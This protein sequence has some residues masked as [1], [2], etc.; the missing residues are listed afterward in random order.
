MIHLLGAGGHAS[1]VVDVA[2]RLGVLDITVWSESEPRTGRFPAMI[3]W[4]SLDQLSPSTPVILAIGDI[5]KRAEL[6]RRFPNAP[7]PLI[8]PSVIVGS[9][10]RIAAGTVIMPR[11]VIN[12]NASIEEDVILNTGCIIEHD[13]VVGRNTHIAPSVSL[14]GTV[15]IG[16]DALVGTG[17][18]VLP[19]VSV[20]SRATVGAGAVVRE[21]VNEGK[22]VVGVPAREVKS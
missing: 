2:M 14:G 4:R 7:D 6:R 8:D 13:C 19:N 3:C 21:H 9:G 18:I 5:A 15:R 12:A 20:G 10:V 22:T 17:A 1:V 11:C 16:S